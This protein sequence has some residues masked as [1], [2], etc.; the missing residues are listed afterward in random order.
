FTNQVI[1]KSANN[2][3]SYALRGALSWK[4]SESF[5]ATL[6]TMYQNEQQDDNSSFYTT[7]SNPDKSN[8]NATRLFPSPSHNKFVLSNLDLRYSGGAVDIISSTSYF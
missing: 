2:H 4:A 7:V 6:S 5:S 3:S 1:D 8:F